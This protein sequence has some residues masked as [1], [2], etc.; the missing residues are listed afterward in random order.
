MFKDKIT[1]L[2]LNRLISEIQISDSKIVFRNKSYNILN[3][4]ALTSLTNILYSECYA[5]KE[6][7]QTGLSKKQQVSIEA[8]SELVEQLSKHNF[9]TERIDGGWHVKSNLNNGYFQ[10]VKGTA[11]KTIHLSEFRNSNAPDQSSGHTASIFLR[12]EDRHRQPTFYYAFSNNALHLNK[13]MTRFY[14]NINSKGAA[15][16]LEELTKKLNHYN[17]PFLFK[18]LNHPSLYYRRDAAVLYLSDEH[19]NLMTILLPELCAKLA[20]YLEEDVPLFSFRFSK[21]LGIAENP[22]S[23]ESFGMHRVGLVAKSLLDVSTKQ[24]DKKE[25]V[26]H[27]GTHFLNEGIQPERPFSNK[28]SKTLF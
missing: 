28:G 24:L 12:K 21:G 10:V 14:W 6:I 15:P 1:L 25:T 8:D 9:T 26:Q 27:I 16:L 13:N 19:V 17:V 23:N 11:Q 2:E 3:E 5:L 22:R 20:D 4:D 18:C 7:Y